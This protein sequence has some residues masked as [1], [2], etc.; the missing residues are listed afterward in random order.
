MILLF[1]LFITKDQNISEQVKLL[2]LY[3]DLRIGFK[4][5]GA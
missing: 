5:R 4:V 3:E 2:E 1:L